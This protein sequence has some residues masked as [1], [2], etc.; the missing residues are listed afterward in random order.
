MFTDGIKKVEVVIVSFLNV[1]KL[2]SRYYSR[3]RVNL[4]FLKIW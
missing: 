1:R 2:T 3:G 4:I